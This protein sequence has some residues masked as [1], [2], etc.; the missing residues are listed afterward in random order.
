MKVIW[1]KESLQQLIEIEQYISRDNPA[2]AVRF[3]NRLIDRAEKIKDYPYKGRVVPE[4]SLNEI[5]EVFEKSYRIVYRI[6]E[7][8]IEIL[9]VFEGHKLLKSSEIIKKGK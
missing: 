8:Q 6:A 2:R 3:I 4:F 1:S 7:N 5:R 9:T